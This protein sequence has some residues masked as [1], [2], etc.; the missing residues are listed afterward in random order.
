LPCAFASVVDQSILHNSLSFD[1]QFV[2]TENSDFFS[3]R[4]LQ[5]HVGELFYKSIYDQ[6]LRLREGDW[7]YFENTAN[8]LFNDSEVEEVKKTGKGRK[9][10]SQAQKEAAACYL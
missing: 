1:I 3:F 10:Q 2:M 9:Q 4:G 5:G 7:F 6:F 8:G